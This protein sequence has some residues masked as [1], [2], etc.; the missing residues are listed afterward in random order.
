VDQQEFNRNLTLI[1]NPERGLFAATPKTQKLS[2]MTP[3]NEQYLADR[4]TQRYSFLSFEG[5]LIGWSYYRRAFLPLAGLALVAPLL[6]TVLELATGAGQTLNLI[7]SLLIV[8]VTSALMFALCRQLD[9]EDRTDVAAAW[10]ES[11]PHLGPLLLSNLLYSIILVIVI[12]PTIYVLYQNGFF[13][14]FAQAQV[15]PETAAAPPEMSEQDGWITMLNLIPFAYLAVAFVWA[16]PLILFFG[17]GAWPA[18]EY[19]RRL[20]SKRWWTLFIL[21]LTFFSILLIFSSLV[22]SLASASPLIANLVG[23]AVFLVVPW[24]NC[25]LY[26]G[27]RRA[28]GWDGKEEEET[29]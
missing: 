2:W 22:G 4:L 28:V 19:S 18:L 6:L 1:T 17:A 3:E 14:W 10:Q 26:V 15:D 24:Y 23:F 27:F 13:E 20:A 12:L 29:E 9:R 16:Y 5:L 7:A 11:T 25:A 8:P 21:I